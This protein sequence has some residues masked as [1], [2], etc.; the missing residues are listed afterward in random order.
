MLCAG[1]PCQG[2]SAVAFLSANRS[3]LAQSSG[4]G[5]KQHVC[6]TC[7]LPRAQ[8]PERSSGGCPCGH[9]AESCLV[10]LLHTQPPH[11][12]FILAEAAEDFRVAFSVAAHHWLAFIPPPHLTVFATKTSMLQEATLPNNCHFPIFAQMTQCLPG[13]SDFAAKLLSFLSGLPQRRSQLQAFHF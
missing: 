3:G 6:P 12:P 8:V 11:R 2:S 9:T 1:E 5:L 4:A 10:L 13:L 7:D